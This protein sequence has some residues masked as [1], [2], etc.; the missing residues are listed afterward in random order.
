MNETFW[1]QVQSVSYFGHTFTRKVWILASGGGR[2]D[3]IGWGCWGVSVVGGGALGIR[4]STDGYAFKYNKK[5]TLFRVPL[6][7]FHIFKSFRS[8]IHLRIIGGG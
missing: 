8:K 3:E 6:Q 7:V 4:T 5:T 2:W 1:Q